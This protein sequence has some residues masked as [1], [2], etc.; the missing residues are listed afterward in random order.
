MSVVNN[1]VALKHLVSMEHLTNEE[2]LGLISRG[3]EYKAGKVAIKDNSRHFAANLFFEN[4]TRTHK[5]FEV[6]ENK[7]GLRVL[8]FNADTSAVNKG[9]TLYDTVLTMS[10]LGTEICVIR[11]PEDDYYQ[12]L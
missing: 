9:E 11:H 7:L 2:V 8:D 5:S 4:S 3:S 12:Q 6:A 1:R 10:A